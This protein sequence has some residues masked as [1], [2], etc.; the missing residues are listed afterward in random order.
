MEPKSPGRILRSGRVV[1]RQSATSNKST[2]GRKKAQN[3]ESRVDNQHLEAD[4]IQ[5]TDT[6]ANVIDEL[7]NDMSLNAVSDKQQQETVELPTDSESD[8]VA[9]DASDDDEFDEDVICLITSKC[10]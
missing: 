3:K 4:F 7:L 5:D 9:V 1:A 10:Y 2:R 8:D 6:N